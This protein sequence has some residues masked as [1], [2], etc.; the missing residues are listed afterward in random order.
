MSPTNLGNL[1]SNAQIAGDG[2]ADSAI[3]SAKIADGTIVNADI[4]SNAAIA[5]TKL[6]GVTQATVATTAPS[7]PQNGDLWTDSNTLI[8]YLYY[9]DGDSNQWVE[10]ANNARGYLFASGTFSSRPAVG[11]AGQMYYAT[12]TSRLYLDTGS[13]WIEQLQEQT[14]STILAVQVFS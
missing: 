4:A 5:A 3:T 10:I 11:T 14:D 6:S 1:P 8:T 9:N 12:D 7:S 2:I 13:A